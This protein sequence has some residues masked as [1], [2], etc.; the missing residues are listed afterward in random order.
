MKNGSRGLSAL[1]NLATAAAAISASVGGAE[2][3]RDGRLGTRKRRWLLRGGWV[4]RQRMAQRLADNAGQDADDAVEAPLDDIHQRG[5]DGD[6]GEG[7]DAGDERIFDGVL[8]IFRVQEAA[9]GTTKKAGV[10]H[11]NNSLPGRKCQRQDQRKWRGGSD[12]SGLVP[13]LFPV[14]R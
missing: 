11:A 7:E 6:D 10:N 2:A 13:N 9:E 14:N 5:E 12:A 8:S 1:R 3:G 4:C